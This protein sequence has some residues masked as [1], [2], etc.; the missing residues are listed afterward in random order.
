MNPLVGN[1][2]GFVVKLGC[3]AVPKS[4][5]APIEPAHSVCSCELLQR[6]NDRL[7]VRLVDLDGSVIRD[8]CNPWITRLARGI[9][10]EFCAGYGPIYDERFEALLGVFGYSRNPDLEPLDWI[11]RN[12]TTYNAIDEIVP[13]VERVRHLAVFIGGDVNSLGYD[14]PGSIDLWSA[15]RCPS[16]R[17]DVRSAVWK[18]NRPDDGNFGHVLFG[19]CVEGVGVESFGPELQV[20]GDSDANHPAGSFLHFDGCS[21]WPKIM[22]KSPKLVGADDLQ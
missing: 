3:L 2:D 4:P 8:S 18:I 12:P 14:N 16:E 22:D 15:Y 10:E 1:H 11:L 17:P 7:R 21:G 9:S 6:D 13:R 20:E 5:P 19:S